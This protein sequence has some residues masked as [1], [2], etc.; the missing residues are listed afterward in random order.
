MVIDLTGNQHATDETLRS[1]G[2]ARYENI[3]MK[4]CRGVRDFK[5]C[6][7]AT[8]IDLTGCANVK[9][10]DLLLFKNAEKVILDDCVNVSTLPFSKVRH[11]SLKNC[12]RIPGAAFRSLPEDLEY[13]DISGNTAVAARDI[14]HLR[15][16]KHLVIF[17]TRLKTLH[18][19]PYLIFL[20]CSHI[21]FDDPEDVFSKLPMANMIVRRMG[22]SDAMY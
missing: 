22:C 9:D 4:R 20:D 14:A 3:S 18:A 17:G 21:E 11:L 7:G 5:I 12:D 8:K 15:N 19:I 1:L 6:T 16:L 10:S 13:L 2:N